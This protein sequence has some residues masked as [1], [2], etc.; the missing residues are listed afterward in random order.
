MLHGLDFVCAYIDDI[1]IASTS[2]EEHYQ[3]IDMVF[4]RLD[5]YGVV[6]N[7]AKCQFGQTEVKFL[8]NLITQE[9]IRPLPRKIETIIIFPPPNSRRKLKQFLGM[10]NLY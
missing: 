1:L 3:H 4:C 6:I 7:L 10:V 9:G 5:K 2:L 8:S